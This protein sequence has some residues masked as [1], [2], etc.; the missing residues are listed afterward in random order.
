MTCDYIT[1]S[2]VCTQPTAATQACTGC[3]IRYVACAFHQNCTP[4]SCACLFGSP[5]WNTIPRLN[6]FVFLPNPP[7]PSTPPVTLPTPPRSPFS[8]FSL[9]PPPP[10]YSLPPPP[11]SFSIPRPPPSFSLPLPQFQTGPSLGTSTSTSLLGK[12]PPS[13]NPG[14]QQNTATPVVGSP[15]KKKRTLKTQ[16][17]LRDEAK[18][19]TEKRGRGFSKKAAEDEFK[20]LTERRDTFTGAWKTNVTISGFKPFATKRRAQVLRQV[21]TQFYWYIRQQL[22]PSMPQPKGWQAEQE[23]QAMAIND[24]IVLAANKDES[25]V[26]LVASLRSLVQAYSLALQSLPLHA[27]APEHPLKKLLTT[28]QYNDARTRGYATKLTDVFAGT[29][30]SDSEALWL[31][32]M[33][34]TTDFIAEV[35]AS[36][37]TACA[38]AVTDNGYRHKL[39]FVTAGGGDIHAEEKLLVVLQRSR[40]R[41][42]ALIY[43]KKRPCAGCG[44]A[45]RFARDKLGHNI[46]FNPNSGGYW[47]P[48]I[49]G[50]VT[51]IQE[52]GIT[53]KV[54]LLQF[55]H[56]YATSYVNH[57]SHDH[58]TA[59][60][61][62][63]TVQTTQDTYANV[64]TSF[65]TEYDSGSDSEAD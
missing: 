21:S 8:V 7:L 42:P 48:P 38:T 6:P 10:S 53:N 34:S 39:V 1:N 11:P 19:R 43:G 15:L 44:L 41:G 59:P 61:P 47:D 16:V 65:I 33:V 30:L 32:Q 62:R 40:S 28:P 56:D 52:S 45:L 57:Q 23:V 29:R 37:A 13:S 27:P 49:Q 24:R 35:D 26:A 54:E 58:P 63:N 46:A 5:G 64:G 36:D 2:T 14:L 25:L 60:T 55:V 17:Q 22:E 51:L 3:G 20:A 31:R 50:L 12:R 9:P 18:K 4:T